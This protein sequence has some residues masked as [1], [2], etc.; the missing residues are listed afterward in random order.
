MGRGSLV[1]RGSVV[2]VELPPT[3]THEQ[4]GGRPCV[5]VSSEAS[6]MNARYFIDFTIPR[7]LTSSSMIP[8]GSKGLEFGML[9]KLL[10]LKEQNRDAR[11]SLSPLSSPQSHPY[12]NGDLR[13]LETPHQTS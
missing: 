5:V 1:K 13:P 10:L 3:R 4:A 12:S 8:F 6:V 11:F 2:V 7:S 9:A